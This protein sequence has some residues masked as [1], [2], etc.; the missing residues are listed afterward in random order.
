MYNTATGCQLLEEIY[1][2]QL[3][4]QSWAPTKFKL[5]QQ[6]SFLSPWAF[7]GLAKTPVYKHAEDTTCQEPTDSDPMK[8]VK[9]AGS[10]LTES[11]CH[12]FHLWQGLTLHPKGSFYSIPTLCK[13]AGMNHHA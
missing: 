5:L 12:F 4:M 3:K 2:L 9:P 7:R 1:L 13:T 11:H 8:V 10:Y 6:P